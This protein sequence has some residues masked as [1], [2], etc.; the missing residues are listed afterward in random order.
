MMTWISII[1]PLFLHD[2]FCL[3]LIPS[4]NVLGQT[5]FLLSKLEQPFRRN[6]MTYACTNDLSYIF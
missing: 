1:S 2:W 5:K 3:D 6:L 4:I